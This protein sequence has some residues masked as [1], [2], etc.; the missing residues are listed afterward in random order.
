LTDLRGN[1]LPQNHFI[2][3]F[4]EMKGAMPGRRP[5]WALPDLFQVDTRV[6]WS[7][8]VSFGATPRPGEENLRDGIDPFWP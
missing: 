8:F 7:I 4:C 1:L 5:G 3:T 2:N 6:S